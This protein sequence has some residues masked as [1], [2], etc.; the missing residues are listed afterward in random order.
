M[1]RIVYYL[2]F[3]ICL[4]SCVQNNK[5]SIKQEIQVEPPYKVSQLVDTIFSIYPNVYVND[6]QNEKFRQHLYFEL[7]KKLTE[8]NA[9]LS[10]IPLQFSQMMKK[11]NKYI[12]KFECGEYTTNDKKLKS[13]VSKTKINFAVFSEVNEELA[14]TLENEAQYILSGNYKGYVDGKLK[15][16]SGKVFNYPNNCYKTSLDQYGT[17]CLGGLLFDKI[18]V[19]KIIK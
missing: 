12:L 3:C 10:E 1:K 7:N 11:G 19:K 6:I 15:L 18:Q 5:T 17:V 13:D 16:P 9:Y 8:D 14:S 4:T 2:L